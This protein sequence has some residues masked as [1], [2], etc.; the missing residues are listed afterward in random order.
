MRL[1]RRDVKRRE[2][3]LLLERLKARFN[4]RIDLKVERYEVVESDGLSIYILD[5]RPLLFEADGDVYPTL[6]F[7]EAMSI[8]P[9]VVVDRGAI[10]HICD[11][12]DVMAPGIVRIEGLFDEGGLV[13]ICDER[14][15]KII[16]LGIA[17]K[18]SEAIRSM[19]RGRA[20][21]NIHYVGDRIWRI[22]RL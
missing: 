8:L 7:D 10:P 12:A 2:G 3:A 18:D 16:A 20:I 4:L 21:R 14:Y 11:G 19:D 5:G 13:A 6:F 15:G 1:K 17:L 22:A 9:R